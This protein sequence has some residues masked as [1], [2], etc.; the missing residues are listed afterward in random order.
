MSSTTS[1][2][3]VIQFS[4]A[5]PRRSDMGEILGIGLT[6]YPPLAGRDENMAG[7]L[8]HILQ[9]P[10]LPDHYRHPESWPVAMRQE[11]GEDEGKSAAARHRE[12]LVAQFR[13]VRRL[14]DDF[15]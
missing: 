1:T 14:L 2:C 13:K 6:H 12:A 7:I 4:K 9:D 10:G 11:Y 15:A 8:R 5:I 3:R